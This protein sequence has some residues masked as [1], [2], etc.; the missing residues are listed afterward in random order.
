MILQ[1]RLFSGDTI[2]QKFGVNE[3][4][5]AVRLF[6]HSKLTNGEMSGDFTGITF[7]SAYPRKVFTEDDMMVP[8]SKLG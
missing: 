4:L 8:L 7:A 6:V 5:A 3:P 1:I 2:T